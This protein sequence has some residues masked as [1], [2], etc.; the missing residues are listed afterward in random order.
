V[1]EH[2]QSIRPSWKG[3]RSASVNAKGDFTAPATVDARRDAAP[4]I[5]AAIPQPLLVLDHGFRVELANPAFL[6]Q[7][8]V[9]REE[10]VGRQLYELG[11]RQ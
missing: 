6:E 1:P 11:N 10:T 4:A 9:R 8:G 7:F 2:Q 5:V 3:H